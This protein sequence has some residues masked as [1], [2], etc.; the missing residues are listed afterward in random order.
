MVGLGALCDLRET[1]EDGRSVSFSV[2]EF[3]LL[4]DGRRVVLRNLGFTIGMG[5]RDP[6]APEVWKTYPT[7]TITQDVLNVV[8]PDDDDSGEDH[9]WEW[10]ASLARERGLMVTAED[11]RALPYRVHLADGVLRLG[12]G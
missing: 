11:L 8:L 12:E 9:P 2:D 5:S 1:S 7:E 3:A 4:E 10:L 6:G